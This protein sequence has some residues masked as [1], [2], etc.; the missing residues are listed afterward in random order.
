MLTL[1]E[2]KPY[3]STSTTADKQNAMLEEEE[4]RENILDEEEVNADGKAGR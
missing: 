2:E 1:M 4:E 3:P